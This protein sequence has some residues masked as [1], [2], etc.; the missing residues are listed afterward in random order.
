[1]YCSLTINAVA[2][3]HAYSRLYLCHTSRHVCTRSLD[4][5]LFDT[6]Q[7]LYRY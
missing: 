4:A 7:L 3:L 6:S 1:M 2:L 5:R